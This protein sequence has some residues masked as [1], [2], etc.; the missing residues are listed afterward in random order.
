MRWNLRGAPLPVGNPPPATIIV[1][2]S[3]RMLAAIARQAGGLVAVLDGF[4]DQDLAEHATLMSKLDFTASPAQIQQ[5]V[6][7]L[8]TGLVKK[9]NILYGENCRL[10]EV[11]F[12]TLGLFSAPI[13]MIARES[14][15]IW[16]ARS[17]ISL[18]FLG[19]DTQTIHAA[20]NI[21][22]LLPVAARIGLPMPPS[23][24]TKPENLTGWLRKMRGNSAGGLGIDWAE[25]PLP[26]LKSPSDYY[27]QKFI[28]GR[29]FGVN[30]AVNHD[31]S[32]MILG[33]AENFTAPI[34]DVP[35]R[36]GGVAG[37]DR[38]GFYGD[39]N[40]WLPQSLLSL[41]WLEIC[42]NLA[43]EF[44]LIGLNGL[45]MVVAPS[46]EIYLLEINP[47]PTAA[48]DLWHGQSG[49]LWQSH[50]REFRRLVQNDSADERPMNG[51]AKAILYAEQTTRIAADFIFPPDAIDRNPPGIIYA[52]QPICSIIA[53][54][55][56]PALAWQFAQ[57][58]RDL[59][60]LQLENLG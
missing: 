50:R 18:T 23:Q 55:K 57:Q 51:M 10:L 2:Q 42:Q 5:A 37:W 19:N 33:L 22:Q 36:W 45:D 6:I 46:G 49:V 14:L 9:Y 52:G 1:A 7:G 60:A 30:F 32:V 43:A 8:A 17:Q 54:A 38:I 34:S 26:P 53:T 44:G 47:R 4:C 41:N 29:V 16:A 24:F 35:M 21:E 48:L 56:T 12:G 20:Q 25:S 11:A 59:L 39:Y 31:G 28:S 3:G 58:R 13:E 27:W 15:S 40:D